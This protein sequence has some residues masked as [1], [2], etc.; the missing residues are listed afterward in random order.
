MSKRGYI[1]T[2]VEQF[3]ECFKDVPVGT[4]FTRKQIIDMLHERFGTNETS[5]IPSDHSYNM[6]NKGIRG[7]NRDNNFFL[8]VGDGEYEY[9]GEHFTG[10]AIS[11]VIQLYKQDFEQVNREERYKW[12][13]IGWYKKHWNI[14]APDFARMFS[15]AFSKHSNLLMSRMY[16]PYGMACEFAEEYP[17]DARAIFRQLFDESIP[18][19]QRYR[20]FRERFNEYITGCLSGQRR[21]IFLLRI[22]SGHCFQRR[23]MWK[24]PFP[25][26][27]WRRWMKTSRSGISMYC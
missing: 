9:V 18:L 2:I 16:Y 15:V 12:V 21:S 22:S 10:M 20:A 27:C 23:G 25:R 8:N 7:L 3:R 6:T 13:A 24:H 14:D 11:D 26:R 5:I 17:E 19:N 1:M 4:R